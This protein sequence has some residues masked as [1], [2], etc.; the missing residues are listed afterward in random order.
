MLGRISIS[1]PEAVIKAKAILDLLLKKGLGI[2][3]KMSSSETIFHGTQSADREFNA[4]LIANGAHVNAED[5]F[6][7]TPLFR[8]VWST[9]MESIQLMIAKGADVY[10]K[11]ESG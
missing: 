8:A 10:A 4:H 7:N 2:S 11:S 5:N 1:K 9:H 6:K 3:R